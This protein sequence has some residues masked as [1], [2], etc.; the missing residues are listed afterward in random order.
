MFLS[1]RQTGILEKSIYRKNNTKLKTNYF[2]LDVVQVQKIKTKA[3][4]TYRCSK[5]PLHKNFK[6]T[7]EQNVSFQA[8][9]KLSCR[10]QKSKAQALNQ[11]LYLEN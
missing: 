6:L 3:K 10:S 8:Y 1:L 2:W 4:N 5:F 11:A 9:L 7:L